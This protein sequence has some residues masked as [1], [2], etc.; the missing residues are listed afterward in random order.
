MDSRLHGN[1]KMFRGNDKMFGGKDKLYFFAI[2][3]LPPD[4]FL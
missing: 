1:D 3:Y 2:F 4:I